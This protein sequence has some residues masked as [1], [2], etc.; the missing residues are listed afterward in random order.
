MNTITAYDRRSIM[1]EAWDRTRDFMA[2]N[3]QGRMASAFA[4]YLAEAW[5]NE[6]SRLQNVRRAEKLAQMSVAEI[7]A[8]LAR[9]ENYKPR[10]DD[11]HPAHLYKAL[12]VREAAA[13]NAAKRALL[14]NAPACSV[15]F[16]KADGSRRVMRI[17]ARKVADHVRGNS[18]T[19]SGRI[20]SHTR[21]FRHPNLLPVWDA[22]ARAIKR[23]NLTTVPRI[24]TPAET[25]SF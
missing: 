7:K 21:A 22:E 4:R 18:A 16:T 8:Q 24:E 9:A 25:H 10:A 19:R 11:Y 2:R 5:I 15:T 23:V 17:E 1:Q 12:E 3:P 13:T 6:K 20:A 14:Q